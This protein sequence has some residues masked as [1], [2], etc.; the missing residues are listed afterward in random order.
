MFARASASASV[1]NG[2]G[3]AITAAPS[4]NQTFYRTPIL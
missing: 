2:V 4:A 1:E 3:A